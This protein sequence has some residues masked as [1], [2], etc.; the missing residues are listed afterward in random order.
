MTFPRTVLTLAGQII[1]EWTA[2]PP[3]D[4]EVLAESFLAITEALKQLG[5]L[6]GL[7]E[8]DL[9]NVI[10]EPLEI[11]GLG[12]FERRTQAKNHKWDTDRLLSVLLATAVD[13]RIPDDDGVMVS[14]ATA[15]EKVVLETA[16]ID[17]WRL[18]ALDRHG[19][20]GRKYR[21]TEWG[22][23]RVKYTPETEKPPEGG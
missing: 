19:I 4:P 10:D 12:T 15:I 1:A 8:A 2:E 18:Q 3:T 11:P 5:A 20:D 6:A 14:P 23:K 16:H 21:T 17:Y 22:R 7:V 9:V 13:A